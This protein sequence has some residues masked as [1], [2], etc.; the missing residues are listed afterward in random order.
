MDAEK[1]AEFFHKTYEK[2]APEYGY[3]TRAET[4][5]N[6]EDVPEENKRLMIH[7]CR[8]VINELG[9]SEKNPF[10]IC[11]HDLLESKCPHCIQKRNLEITKELSRQFHFLKVNGKW[12]TETC[13]MQNWNDTTIPLVV[14]KEGHKEY[15]FHGGAGQ[16][17]ERL[18]E[19][20]GF[21]GSELAILLFG[22]IKRLEKER[23]REGSGIAGLKWEK[24]KPTKEGIYLRI[25]PPVSKVVRQD[26]SD[27]NGE[28]VVYGESGPIPLEKVSDR[29]LWFGPVSNPIDIFPELWED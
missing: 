18:N 4:A 11:M 28:L 19:R 27:W 8:L 5:V 22:R 2:F 25:N 7:V 23:E 10:H 15:V 24:K 20:G 29:F 12:N 3:K 17:L 6:W 1:L 16:S 14:A 26:I 13:P 21:A 9:L